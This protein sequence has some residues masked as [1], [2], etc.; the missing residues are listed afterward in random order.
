MSPHASPESRNLAR[1]PSHA[2]HIGGPISF[3]NP[4][5][6]LVDASGSSRTAI[7]RPRSHH[8]RS[9]EDGRDRVPKPS[10]GVVFHVWQT[11]NNR[12][13]RHAVAVHVPSH[14]AGTGVEL[15]KATNAPKQVLRGIGRMIMKYPVWDVSY[16]V[17]I[18]FTIGK[19]FNIL[20][21]YIVKY[22]YLTFSCFF[23]PLSAVRFGIFTR[24]SAA[25][26]TPL[27]RQAR[28]DPSSGSSTASSPGC[29]CRARPRRSR[30]RRA[31]AAASRPSS[32]PP[33]SSSGRSC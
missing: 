29:P 8:G 24:G 18:M 3:L 23:F 21:I 20:H 7:H 15:P 28:Q 22:E 26:S 4:T 9:A 13:G 25:V 6:G 33:S 2:L 1:C 16:D 11:R 5:M 30:A 10:P 27:T 14:P 32:A 12:K 19:S 17:A 31:W